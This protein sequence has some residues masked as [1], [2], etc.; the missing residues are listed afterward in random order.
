MNNKY[1]G[2]HIWNLVPDEIKETA[3]ILYSFKSLIM[4]WEDPKC[5]RNMCN[6][7][8]FICICDCVHMYIVIIEK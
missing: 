6:I 4:T 8:I 2:S 7:F 1:Y 3:D 5:Q